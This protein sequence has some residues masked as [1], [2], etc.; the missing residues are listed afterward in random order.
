MDPE[1]FNEVEQWLI[2]SQRDLTVARVLFQNQLFDM[3]VYHCQ[4]CA[5]KALKAYLAYQQK[6]LQKTYNLVVLLENCIEFEPSFEILRE[7]AES[8]TPYATE[9]RYPGDTAQPE[10][11]DVEEALEM[12]ALVLNVVTQ[13]IPSS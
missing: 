8:L 12:A 5:E 11:D 10:K 7:S 2:K 6:S 13:A 3:T 4:Q 1:H 9:F